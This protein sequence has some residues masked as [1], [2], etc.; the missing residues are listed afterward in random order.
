[1]PRRSKRQD[2]LDNLEAAKDDLQVARYVDL[3]SACIQLLR[4]S[5]DTDTDDTDLSD[6]SMSVSTSD[7]L[8]D[9]DMDL[10]SLLTSSNNPLANLITLSPEVQAY[11][12][13]ILALEDEVKQARYLAT[14]K[15]TARAPQLQL[16]EQWAL[17]GDDEKFRRKL[18]VDPEVF[19]HL[20]NC[21]QDHPGFVSKSNNPQFPVPIQLAIFLNGAGHYGNAATTQDLAEW[22]GVSLGTVYNCIRR[23]MIAIL[24]LHDEYIHFDPLEEDDQ[25]ERERA[26][27]WVEEQCGIPEWRHGFLC[28]DGTPL[29]L[30]QKPGW[31]GEGFYDR[32]SRYSISAQVSDS[33]QHVS[34]ESTSKIGYCPTSQSAYR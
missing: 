23:V 10:M 12:N 31:H 19:K 11:E 9:S 2:I 4:S 17:D 5:S 27:R 13:Q 24:Q 20:V 18:R 29:N 34:F 21:I 7:I 25:R 30:F 1:M 28:V 33:C 32:K 22:A 6:S 8:E 14:R 3:L 26:K 15:K 16:L